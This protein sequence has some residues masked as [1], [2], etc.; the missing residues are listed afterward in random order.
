MFSLVHDGPVSSLAVAPPK[1]GV[2][3][4][5]RASV[6]DGRAWTTLAP[7]QKP[8][9]AHFEL[10][11]GRDFEPRLMGY[12]DEPSARS[13]GPHSFYKR[14]KGGRWQDEPSEL[15][16]FASGAGALYGVLGVVDPEVVCR[17]GAQCL[18][19]R[20]SGWS[21]VPAHAAPVRI[22][23]AGGTAWA[24]YSNHVERLEPAGFARFGPERGWR[25]PSGIWVDAEGA[26]WI[27]E[28][29]ERA[30]FRLEHGTWLRVES[31]L[32]EP[33]ALW[34]RANDDLWL[35]GAGGAAHFDGTTW[36]CANDVR[37]PLRFIVALGD[38]LWL[39]GDAGVFRG[40]AK[41]AKAP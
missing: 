11:F 24:L 39:A 32:A 33:R 25:D 15:G 23:L 40:Q 18:I 1:I 16:P 14:F 29:A 41:R 34:G 8:D 37:G 28:P 12:L 31:P 22:A 27:A 19:K 21:R 38:E 2:L 35:V 17:P 7:L 9:G 20:V 13:D 3:A 30:L 36:Q 6:F 10:F 4:A 5:E 26:P